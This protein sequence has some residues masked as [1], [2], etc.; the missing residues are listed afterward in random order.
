MGIGSNS[1]A[2]LLVGTGQ[3]ADLF[4]VLMKEY[5]LGATYFLCDLDSLFHSLNSLQ[6]LVQRQ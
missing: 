5:T 1:L 3:C 6:S 2:T 4:L